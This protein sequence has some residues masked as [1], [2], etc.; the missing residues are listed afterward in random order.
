MGSISFRASFQ[1]KEGLLRSGNTGKIRIARN[2]G[3]SIVVPQEATFELQEKVF[4]FAVGDSNKVASK[5]LTIA[6]TSG[7]YYLVQDGISAGEKI[8]YTGLDRLRD[9]A[10]IQPQPMSMDSLLKARPM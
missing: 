3:N 2:L 5:P 1:N 8:V 6:G 7:N 9:G 10:V 4:V